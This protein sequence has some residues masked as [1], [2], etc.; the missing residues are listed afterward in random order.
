MAVIYSDSQIACLMRETKRLPPNWQTKL[1]QFRQKRGHKE[2][3]ISVSGE[4]GNE[5]FI[6][7]RQ[8]SINPLDFSVVL[9]VRVPK[10]N[11]LFRLRRYNGKSH[12]HTNLIEGNTFYDFHIH[13]ASERYQRLGTRE[14]AYAEPTSRF[15]NYY[16]ALQCLFADAAFVSSP[17]GQGE[18]FE[19][20]ERDEHG[21]D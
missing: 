2:A 17:R 21:K 18:L 1:H 7:I 3:E 16:T 6:I 9:A 5:F 10:T 4:A 20:V 8:N 12:E 14:D 11:Q 13:C 19:E 15:D